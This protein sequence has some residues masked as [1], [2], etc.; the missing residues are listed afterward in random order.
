MDSADK[1]AG[2]W[3]AGAELVQVGC[4]QRGDRTPS[5]PICQWEFEVRSGFWSVAVIIRDGSPEVTMVEW[6]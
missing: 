3:R 4:W 5:K 1:A 2:T 6:E